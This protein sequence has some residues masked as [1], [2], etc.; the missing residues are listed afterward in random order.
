MRVIKID[1]ENKGMYD[2]EIGD[3]WQD[4]SKALHQKAEYFQ[5]V[6]FRDD[7]DLIVDEEGL[8]KNYGFGFKVNGVP[9]FGNGLLISTQGEEYVDVYAKANDI[10]IDLQYVK[11]SD[12]YTR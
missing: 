6:R 11:V 1:A 8:F 9:F 7:I 5:P 4:I 2:I 12:F 3:E 10:E